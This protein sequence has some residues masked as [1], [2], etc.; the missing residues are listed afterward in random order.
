MELRYAR[1][2]IGAQYLYDTL[3][4]RHVLISPDSK[5]PA[6]DA[7][8]SWLSEGKPIIEDES[9]ASW[10]KVRKE[11]QKLLLSSDWTILPDSPV[12]NKEEWL[13][14]RQKLRDL[15]EYYENPWDVQWPNP[16]KVLT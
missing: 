12:L 14:Y 16:P 13:E 15:T 2:H 7:A 8:I 10:Y 6:A 11:R 1:S 9:K 3:I 4:Q 5:D